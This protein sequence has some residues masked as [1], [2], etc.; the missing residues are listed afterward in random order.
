MIKRKR[1]KE[2]TRKKNE[3]QQ[4]A[5]DCSIFYPKHAGQTQAAETKAGQ[6]F[7]SPWH[8]EM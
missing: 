2:Q 6:E 5:N 8:S 3:E 1:R 7:Y 4:N